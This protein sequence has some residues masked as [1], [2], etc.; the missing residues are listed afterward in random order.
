MSTSESLYHRLVAEGDDPDAPRR[1]HVEHRGDRA[2]R[3]P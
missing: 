3:H 2:D 1:V